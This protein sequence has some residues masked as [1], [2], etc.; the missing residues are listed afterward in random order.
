MP[1]SVELPDS[2]EVIPER[3]GDPDR[4]ERVG[5]RAEEVKRARFATLR[6]AF[7]ALIGSVVV[8][9]LFF[10]A[11]DAINPSQTRALS[12]V[13]LVLAVLWLAHAWRRLFLGGDG[14]RPDRERRGF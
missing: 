13:V 9:Y 1:D 6:A 10:V 7:W 5:R 11:L 8:L 12:I 4:R 2:G 3:R 14:S